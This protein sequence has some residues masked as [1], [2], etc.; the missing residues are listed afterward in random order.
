MLTGMLLCTLIYAMLHFAT[1]EGVE[2]WGSA[3]HQHGW[4]W[5]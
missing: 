2:I 4:K 3:L 5:I 1:L